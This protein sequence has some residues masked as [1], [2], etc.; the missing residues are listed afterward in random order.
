[1]YAPTATTSADVRQMR[2]A[3]YSVT[4]TVAYSAEAWMREDSLSLLVVWQATPTV[5]WRLAESWPIQTAES[6]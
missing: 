5:R 3:H 2:G 6:K 4:I 1:V